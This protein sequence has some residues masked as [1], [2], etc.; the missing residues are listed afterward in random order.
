MLNRLTLQSAM[1]RRLVL[2]NCE[3]LREVYASVPQPQDNRDLPLPAQADPAA[4]SS[5]SVRREL[6]LNGCTSMPDG[7]KARLKALVLHQ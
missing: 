3:N 1:L 4:G 2:T 7:V 5:S 6:K